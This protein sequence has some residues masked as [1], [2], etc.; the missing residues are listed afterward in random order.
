MNQSLK[1]EGRLEPG[2]GN[3]NIDYS[4]QIVLTQK[5]GFSLP[6]EIQPKFE[7]EP[8]KQIVK[9]EAKAISEEQK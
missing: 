2:K 1:W 3:T 4:K 7:P 8:L 9:E 6:L 5:T